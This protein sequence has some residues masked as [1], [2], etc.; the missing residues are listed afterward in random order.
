MSQEVRVASVVKPNHRAVVGFTKLV[1]QDPGANR[2]LIGAVE[3]VRGRVFQLRRVSVEHNTAVAARRFV[4]HQRH[5][6][7]QLEYSTSYQV[8]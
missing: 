5:E 2:H 4:R 6:A 1:R 3:H 8:F 7:T